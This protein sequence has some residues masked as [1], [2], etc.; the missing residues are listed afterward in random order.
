MVDDI[1]ATVSQTPEVAGTAASV[2]GRK[3]PWVAWSQLV[4]LGVLVLYFAVKAFLPAWTHLNS[5]FPNYYLT[6]SLYRRGYPVEQVYDWTWFQRQWDHTG[7][8]HRV[9]SYV[10]LTEPSALVIAPWAGLPPLRA[11]HV[12]LVMNLLFLA[13]TA[14]LLKFSTT[15]RMP[16]I[17]LLIFLA[18]LPLRDNFL[19]GQWHVFV[20]LLLTLAAWLYFSRRFFSS[21][22][23]LALAAGMKI[24]PALFLIYFVFKKQWRAEI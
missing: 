22:I 19:L 15:I 8:E 6:A 14:I 20:L 24:Y 10:P 1:G 13:L 2:P 3:N 11:K 16:T 5:D 18:T 4:L 23:V 21:G 9:V 17:A 7:S 12:W